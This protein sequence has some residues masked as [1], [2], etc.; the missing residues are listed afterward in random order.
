MDVAHT[1]LRRPDLVTRCSE[2]GHDE[3]VYYIDRDGKCQKCVERQIEG[4]EK[5][6]IQEVWVWEC[7]HCK[8]ENQCGDELNKIVSCKSCDKSYV[9]TF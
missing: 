7:P 4:K 6:V 9:V 3:I 2:C 1:K 8:V 5:V